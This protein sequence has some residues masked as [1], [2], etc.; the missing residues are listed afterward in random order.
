MPEASTIP[1]AAASDQAPTAVQRFRSRLSPAATHGTPADHRRTV[2]AMLPRG[3]AVWIDGGVSRWPPPVKP[4]SQAESGTRRV[5]T[6]TTS[7]QRKPSSPATPYANAARREASDAGAH[8]RIGAQSARDEQVRERLED[9][10]ERP[11]GSGTSAGGR[12]PVRQHEDDPRQEES[13]A[14]EDDRRAPRNRRLREQQRKCYA[15][16]ARVKKERA[17]EGQQAPRHGR[18]QHHRQDPVPGAH[19]HEQGEADRAQVQVR[20]HGIELREGQ[21]GAVLVDPEGHAQRACGVEVQQRQGHGQP[22]FDR[23]RRATEP[24]Q[25]PAAHP[26]RGHE[27]HRAGPGHARSSDPSRSGR[28]CR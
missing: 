9:V 24:G 4:C 8:A 13:D 23:R 25:H 26:Q 5:S 16:R 1:T 18:G 14:G 3:T 22:G 12:A 17:R 27:G 15:P 10:G 28:R 2:A 21:E 19:H 11:V 7:W 6:P 20:M